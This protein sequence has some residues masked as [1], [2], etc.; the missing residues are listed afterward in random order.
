MEV[1]HWSSI[2]TLILDFDGVFTDNKVYL[3]EDGI[4][5]VKL[6]RRDGL[7]FDLLKFFMKEKGWDLE[8]FVLSKEK[9]VVVQKRCKKLDINCFSG[10]K[11]KGEF[12]VSY[13]NEKFGESEISK[14][15]VVFLG[16]DINDLSAINV[17]GFSVAPSDSHQLVLN[18]V[19]LVLENKGGD[20]FIRNFV[21][22]LIQI[23]EMGNNNLL[24]GMNIL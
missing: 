13:L 19:D 10:K 12:I 20:C 6:D 18:S 22:Q 3:S 1:P 21:E 2:H 8:I 11:N 7:A 14:K 9:N 17:A 16:N 4:E 24:L 23:S 15:G 5:S